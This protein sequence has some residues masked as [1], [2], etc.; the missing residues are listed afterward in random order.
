MS[1]LRILIE[2]VLLTVLT[3]L[4]CLFGAYIIGIF[5][6]VFALLRVIK[7]IVNHKNR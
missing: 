1:Q 7:F 2:A 4:L 3:V 5:V 6:S